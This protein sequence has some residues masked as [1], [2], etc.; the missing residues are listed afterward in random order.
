MA[1]DCIFC[2]IATG[3]VPCNRIYEDQ[4]VLA[5]LDIRP[6]SDGHTL[7]IPKAHFPTLHDCPAEVLTKVVAFLPTIAKAVTD[8]MGA[9]AYNVLSNNG[10][11]AGQLVDHLHFHIIPRDKGDGIFDRWQA[12]EYDK[13]RADIIAGM[14]RKKL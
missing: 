8:A 6:V 9:A 13:D 10:T 12:Y 14:I 3:N 2:S 4:A 1:H 7:V 11:A 5:F